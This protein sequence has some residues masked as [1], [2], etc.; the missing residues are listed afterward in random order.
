MKKNSKKIQYVIISVILSL[1]VHIFILLLF[2]NIRIK[3]SYTFAAPQREKSR[4]ITFTKTNIIDSKTLQDLREKSIVP[5]IP[6]RSSSSPFKTDAKIK[7][8]LTSTNKTATTPIPAI[9]PPS[10]FKPIAMHK[11]QLIP[12][13][14]QLDGDK[15]TKKE[16]EYNHLIIPKVSR[17]EYNIPFLYGKP[18]K[19][20]SLADVTYPPT[21][22]IPLK[23]SVSSP[24][25]NLSKK[26][27]LTSATNLIAS[28]KTT[29]IDQFLNVQLYKYPEFRE[30]GC[31]K[32]VIS[33]SADAKHFEA[34]NKDIIF[35]I[36]ISGS[37]TNKQLA[38]FVKGVATSISNLDPNDR[39]E[40]VAF[41]NKPF[42]SFG[43]MKMATKDNI[44]K[45]SIFLKKLKQSG[46]TN[47]YK[48][49][50]PYIDSNYKTA[51]RP[52]LIFILSDGN[53]NSGDIVD[54]RNFIETISNKNHQTA[55]IFTFTNARS[56]NAF[57]LD[58]LAYR[59]RGG[60]IRAHNVDNSSQLLK[61]DINSTKHI[62]LENLNYQIS[63]NLSSETFPKKLSNLYMGRSII[64][65]GRYQA[66]I[67]KINLRII[68]TDKNG[69]KHELVYSESL[70]KALKGSQNLPKQWAQQYVFHLYSKLT[71]HY[72]RQIEQKL[73]SISKQYSI[74]ISYRPTANEK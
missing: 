46:S 59:N 26:P 68:G 21:K 28:K 60:F 73:H 36:D 14:I 62:I 35:L 29:P 52:L 63:S 45:A 66:N 39:F 1:L 33:A 58:L 32:I 70:N 67:S 54:S 20:T 5:V 74:P 10:N 43:K 53:L 41:E 50:V 56:S 25:I 69:N 6:P 30:G 71:A 24:K 55:S 16:L 13:I 61:E 40:V 37:I 27:S 47:L 9:H 11:K 19:H 57:L 64:L 3:H 8:F 17:N 72:N 23:L 31:F 44:K 7:P 65:F 42:V 34:F 51:G 48:A 38:E 49:L 15:L 2:E 4:I 22:T 12:K 18:Q